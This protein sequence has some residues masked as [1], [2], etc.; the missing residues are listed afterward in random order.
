MKP[1]SVTDIFRQQSGNELTCQQHVSAPEGRVRLDNLHAET[2]GVECGLS[3]HNP[4]MV[5]DTEYGSESFVYLGGR[6]VACW[7]TSNI[8]C[9]LFVGWFLKC[10]SSMLVYLRDRST[11][12]SVHAAILRWKVQIKLS[13]SPSHSLLTQGRPVQA[14]TL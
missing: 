3:L 13:I 9:S 12:T 7:C 8:P 4:A 2:E 1:L 10:P 14:L 5:H 6:G 11:Q